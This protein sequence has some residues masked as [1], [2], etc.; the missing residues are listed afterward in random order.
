MVLYMLALIG[1]NPFRKLLSNKGFPPNSED[2]TESWF[3][4]ICFWSH[5]VTDQKESV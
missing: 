2:V 5:K 1:P 4:K 3:S